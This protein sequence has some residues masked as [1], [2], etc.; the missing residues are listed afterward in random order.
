MEAIK[1]MMDKIE[2]RNLP[3]TLRQG[4]NFKKYQKEITT[5]PRAVAIANDLE[6]KETTT[7]QGF[8][9]SL[10]KENEESAQIV[11]GFANQDSSMSG[12]IVT[13]SS[14]VS[15]EIL[16]QLSELD[17]LQTQYNSLLEQYKTANNSSAEK[18]KTTLNNIIN[19]I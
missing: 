15:Q 10:N 8:N 7:I 18:V 11:E 14:P 19:K 1:S 16:S 13:P 3:P 6:E 9:N 17:K 4:L 2:E 12:S 5:N